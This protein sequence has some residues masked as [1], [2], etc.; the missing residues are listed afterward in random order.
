MGEE[1]KPQETLAAGG[2]LSQRFRLVEAVGQGGIGAVWLARDEQLDGEPVA[3][4][5]LKEELREDRRAVADLKREVLLTRRLRHPHI[6]AVYTFW[7]DEACRFIT[8]EYVE[9]RNLADALLDR[10]RPYAPAEIL[11]WMDQIAAALDYAHGQGVLHR[12]VKPANVLLTGD[13]EPR[14]AD[15]GIARTAREV[16]NRLTG[17]LSFGTLVYV[18]PEQLMGEALDG[19]SDQYSL[20][21]S[22]YELLSGHPP[23]H[24]GSIVTQIQFKPVAALE[25]VGD[26]VNR[27]LQRGLAKRPDDRFSSCSAL[28]EALGD[29]LS[30]EAP[31]MVLETPEVVV[32][33]EQEDTAPLPQVDDSAMNSR[34]G[35][36]LVEGGVITAGQR[37]RLLELQAQEGGRLGELVVAQ[38]F[39]T[40]DDVAEALSVQLHLPRA[41][42]AADRDAEAVRLIPECTARARRCIPL[43]REGIVLSVAMA[44]PLDLTTINEIEASF[45]VTVAP[46]VATE[47]EVAACLDAL[48]AS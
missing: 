48:N 5:V 6:L 38:G 41:D 25:G 13:G 27:V 9:G 42:F 36:L 33:A 17:E 7:E 39:A 34:L 14:L 4:K 16:M 23:F 45:G 8:M 32:S 30:G 1:G 21:A 18:S 46:L 15:F 47:S 28:C 20:A 26:G 12:D 24:Q 2:L 10:G 31:A 3:C 29:A 35:A 19:R 44:D 37:D 40:E 43:R 22:I 11:P